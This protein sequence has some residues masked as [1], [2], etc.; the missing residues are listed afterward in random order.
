MVDLIAKRYI[1]ALKQ[2]S[3]VKSLQIISDI[4]AEL[5]LS[6]NDKNFTS[7]INNPS[8][9]AQD[10]SSIILE[11][12]ASAKSETL[13]NLIKLLSEHNRLNVIPAIA[14]ELKKDLART[15]KSYTGVVYSD[16]KMTAKLIKEL[17][18]GLGAK[19][20]SKITLSF[21]QNDFNS[22]KVDVE[23][24]GIEINFSKTRI[25][26]QIIDHIVKAI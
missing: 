19:Y 15:N 18:T 9:K 8:V 7:I 24:L 11:A 2:G 10:K 5:A 1:R 16:E 13:N 14:T 6:F 3:D 12:V 23:D 4:F 21:V 20:N 17:S 26:N 25:N 22:I